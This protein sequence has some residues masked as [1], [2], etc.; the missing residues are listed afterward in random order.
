MKLYVCYGTW[1]KAGPGVHPCGVAYEALRGAGYVPAVIRSYG[2][3]PM[4]GV[5]NFTPGRRE[6]KRLTGNHWVPVIVADD[7]TVV[8][9]SKRIAEW[10]QVHPAQ[11][12]GR[13]GSE[14]R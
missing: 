8:Q 1:R 2:L 7:G 14:A 10:A 6:V 9:E 13:P 11:G 3:G 4:P 5:F 12:A